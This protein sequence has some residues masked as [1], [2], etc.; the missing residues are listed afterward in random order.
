MEACDPEVQIPGLLG[1][2]SCS[3]QTDNKCVHTNSALW[4]IE[5]FICDQLVFV[6]ECS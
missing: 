3:T 5:E 6:L 4:N 2:D 1:N